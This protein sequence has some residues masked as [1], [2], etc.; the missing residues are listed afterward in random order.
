MKQGKILFIDDKPEEGN[1]LGVIKKALPDCDILVRENGKEGLELLK[2]DREVSLVLLD[3]KMPQQFALDEDY[4]GIEVLKEIKKLNPEIPVI[5]VTVFD[6]D[7]E[8]I[9]GSI[10]AGAFH[11]VPKPL[12]PNYLAL[13]VKRA[14]KGRSLSRDVSHLKEVINVREEME[15][16]VKVA[17]SD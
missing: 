13:Q 1:Y 9:V 12:D 10:K 11:Y 2:K 4:E 7:I 3:I 5:M 14:L 17:L 16:P 8:K 15:R 6:T